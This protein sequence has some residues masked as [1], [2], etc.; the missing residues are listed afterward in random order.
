MT[1]T[2]T[3]FEPVSDASYGACRDPSSRVAA[4]PGHEAGPVDTLAVEK[5]LDVG[6]NG[7]HS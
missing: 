5:S 4:C 1:H 2:G 6:M 7:L 3:G